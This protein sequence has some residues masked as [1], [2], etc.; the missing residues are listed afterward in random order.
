MKLL[1][2]D[3]LFLLC[4]LFLTHCPS[5]FNT[6][7]GGQHCKQY[8]YNKDKKQWVDALGNAVNCSIVDNNKIFPYLPDT[9]CKHWQETFKA[10]T[11]VKFVEI[12]IR[13]DHNQ[14]VLLQTYCVKQRYVELDNSGQV[15]LIDKGAFCLKEN[16]DQ[17]KEYV[18]AS[19]D[20]VYRKRKDASPK[21]N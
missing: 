16:E 11:T 9:G 5:S 20:G 21:S 4:G 13:V 14:G 1:S 2:L 17:E 3:K 6:G 18:F 7:G 19:C 10:D 12:P 15:L 8:N